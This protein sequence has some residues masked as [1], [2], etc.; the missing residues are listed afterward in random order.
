M[1]TSDEEGAGT[2]SNLTLW[3]YGEKRDSGPLPLPRKG[4]DHE[5]F[6]AGSVEEFDVRVIFTPT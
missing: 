4:E 1:I 6:S 5:S 2:T 3:V